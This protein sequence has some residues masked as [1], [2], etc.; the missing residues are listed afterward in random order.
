MSLYDGWMKSMQKPKRRQRTIYVY[1]VTL[2]DNKRQ[3]WNAFIDMLTKHFGECSD[4][5]FE[6]HIPY[7]IVKIPYAKHGGFDTM[8][9]LWLMFEEVESPAISQEFIESYKE[10]FYEL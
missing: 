6:N 2:D 4:V 8:L 5:E 9:F 7:I 10:V 3:H 1:K